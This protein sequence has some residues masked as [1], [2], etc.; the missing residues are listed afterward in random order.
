LVSGGDSNQPSAINLLAADGIISQVQLGL[1]GGQLAVTV[2][3]FVQPVSG[4]SVLRPK[5]RERELIY[6][7]RKAAKPG[8]ILIY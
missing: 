6:L 1:R 4:C 5:Q 8:Y 7:Q 3:C 2:T